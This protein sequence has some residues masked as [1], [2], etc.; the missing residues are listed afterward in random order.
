MKT[1]DVETT[2][3]AL[4]QL[5]EE[6]MRIYEKNK[7]DMIDGSSPVSRSFDAGRVDGVKWAMEIFDREA[8]K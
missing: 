5:Y 8:G 3:A 4:S 6:A 1:I 7:H 2:R